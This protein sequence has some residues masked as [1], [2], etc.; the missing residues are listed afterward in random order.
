MAEPTVLDVAR[1]LIRQRGVP[2]AQPEFIVAYLEAEAVRPWRPLLF[3]EGAAWFAPASAEPPTYSTILA[4]RAGS[5]RA[6]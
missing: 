4:H 2:C 1:H 3:V 5:E 6:S